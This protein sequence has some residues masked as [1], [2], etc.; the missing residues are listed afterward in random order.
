MNCATA[1]AFKVIYKGFPGLLK[2]GEFGLNGHF[3][4]DL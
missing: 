4:Y 3:G 2:G 1:K